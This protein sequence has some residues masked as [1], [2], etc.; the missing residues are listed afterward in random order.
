MGWCGPHMGKCDGSRIEHRRRATTFQSQI[1]FQMLWKVKCQFA[2]HVKL[3]FDN[4]IGSI[5]N[6]YYLNEKKTDS[7][8][9]IHS[10]IVQIQMQ[11]DIAT[12]RYPIGP[13]L[14]HG[15]L[16]TAT[17]KK[18]RK[19]TAKQHPKNIHVNLDYIRFKCYWL[20]VMLLAMC[21]S[22]Q[23]LRAVPFSVSFVI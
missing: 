15:R 22:V 2:L 9:Q 17:E 19:T 11:I 12:A 5:L 23:F 13:W 18:R 10:H 7:S 3:N 8:A 1:H 6:V 20:A 21:A 16:L 14:L 4:G